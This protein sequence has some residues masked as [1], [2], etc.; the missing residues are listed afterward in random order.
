VKSVES[1]SC[2]IATNPRQSILNIGGNRLVPCF[3][4]AGIFILHAFWNLESRFFKVTHGL[5]RHR[6]DSLAYTFIFLFAILDPSFGGS[7]ENPWRD[8]DNTTLMASPKVD[9]EITFL[10]LLLS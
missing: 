3:I 2:C 8:D 6:C 5:V 7:L 9:D 1:R 4:F 10:R